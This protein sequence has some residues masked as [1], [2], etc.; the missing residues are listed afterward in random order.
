MKL[1]L[2]SAVLFSFPAVAA[3]LPRIGFWK[4][5]ASVTERATTPETFR[6]LQ[7]KYPEQFG[8]F[9]AELVDNAHINIRTYAYS[10]PT[11]CPENDPR[12]TYVSESY[13]GC[14]KPDNNNGDKVQSCFQTAMPIPNPMDPCAE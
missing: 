4:E 7:Q 13:G 14:F 5:I 10:G 3:E 2:F 9:D 8:Q 12:L 1:A 11:V 6:A